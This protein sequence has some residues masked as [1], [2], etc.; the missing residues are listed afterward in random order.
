[1][2]PKLRTEAPLAWASRSITTTRLPRLA[3]A[4]AH[5]RPTM[6]APITARSNERLADMALQDGESGKL[7]CRRDSSTDAARRRPS[8]DRTVT[9]LLQSATRPGRLGDGS[10]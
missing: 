10:A 8:K 2:K 6:P 1:M 9:Q 3:A 5:P 4:R 7:A